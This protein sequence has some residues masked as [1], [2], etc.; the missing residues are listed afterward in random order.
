MSDSKFNIW[1]SSFKFFSVIA[2]ATIIY[3]PST[4]GAT[5]EIDNLSSG[6]YYC[7]PAAKADLHCDNQFDYKRI[8]DQGLIDQIRKEAQS[9]DPEAILKESIAIDLK[10]AENS[11]SNFSCAMNS[12]LDEA[13]TAKNEKDK[14]VAL[15]KLRELMGHKDDSLKL[16][17]KALELEPGNN[18]IK[19]SLA[20]ANVK[21]GALN[22]GI[23]L[24]NEVLKN[25][26]N[27]KFK[28]IG[29]EEVSVN[30]I[31]ADAF[32]KNKDNKNA[33]AYYEKAFKAGGDSYSA[34]R[35]AEMLLTNSPNDPNT[36]KI[37]AELAD[38][39]SDRGIFKD[40]KAV[41]SLMKGD[42]GEV[43]LSSL[44]INIKSSRVGI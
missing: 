2:S 25:D 22:D 26:P 9:K 15:A 17:A 18:S 34:G 21:A 3:V 28:T 42:K 43:K 5:S 13:K 11:A 40:V 12:F 19:S 16:Y 27:A 10:A 32:M 8:K 31:V 4:M 36:P 6:W 38:K 24:A 7:N 30:V 14:L 1:E 23:K 39:I 41:A 37:L 33:M 44:K 35:Y 29:N 20:L